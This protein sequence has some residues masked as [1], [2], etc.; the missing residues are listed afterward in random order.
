MSRLGKKQKTTKVDKRKKETFFEKS[1][2]YL[3]NIF[4]LLTLIIYL[5]GLPLYFKNG[6]NMVASTK[7]RYFVFMSVYVLGFYLIYLAGYYIT[8]GS[9]KGRRAT[10]EPLNKLDISML[11]LLAVAF[12][13]HIFSSYKHVGGKSDNFFYEG[14]FFGINGWFMGFFTYFILVG[15]YFFIS[16]FLKYSNYI[17]IPVV[18]ATTL[19]FIWG[20]INRYGYFPFHIS[21][22]NPRLLAPIGNI[23]WF[24][25]YASVM[26]PVIIGLYWGTEK[27]IIKGLLSI[28]VIFSYIQALVNG[29]DSGVF[30]F[31][32]TMFVLF[33]I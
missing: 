27:K 5:I 26:A 11:S 1:Y 12:I 6:F 29:S 20:S 21:T 3:G 24:A 25:S 17:W 4:S 14:S 28:P 31:A 16:R 8:Y 7:Y 2:V 22:W 9:F 30:S 33:V 10:Y 13:S 23:N 18:P 19:A 15:L 32:I